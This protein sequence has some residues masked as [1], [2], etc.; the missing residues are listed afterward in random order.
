MKIMRKEKSILAGVFGFFMLF[1]LEVSAEPFKLYLDNSRTGFLMVEK[2]DCEIYRT[3][4]GRITLGFK[5]GNFLF[6]FGP[7]VTF[8]KKE[9]IDWDRTIQGL[10]ARYQELCTRF[11]TGQLTKQE[12]ET[13]LATIESIE[14]EAYELHEKMIAGRKNRRKSF[15]EK[16]EKETGE[17]KEY[18]N[19]YKEINSKLDETSSDWP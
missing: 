6:D 18:R 17:F 11:N 19:N 5:M 9:G 16:M 4:D 15:F 1:P 10:V 13:R 2:Q 3:K 14:K 7:E 12:Y 8:G